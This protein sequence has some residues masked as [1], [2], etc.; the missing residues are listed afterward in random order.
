M[1]A[2]SCS[3]FVEV[4]A[5]KEP[6]PGGGGAS[7][8][9]GAIG[10]A[11]GN[12]TGSLTAGKKKYADVEDEVISLKQKADAL[13]GRLIELVTRDAEV[14]APLARA[15]RLPTGTESQRKHKAEIMEAC[16]RRCCAVP[17]EIMERCCEA[18][19]ICERLAA[20]GAAIAISDVGCG[21][22]C[23]RAALEAASLNVFIN[24]ASMANRTQAETINAQAR[25]MLK[26][27]V[28]KAN[29]IFADVASR[30]K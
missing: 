21:V 4:L 29:L 3:D 9:V 28:A 18:I 30:F 19:D 13:Q 24:T 23:L 7:A 10:T 8:L 14:F 20:V 25:Q 16:L 12:M 17:L 1:T 11:L 5:S 26:V 15:Y 6:V 22:A 2:R 27:Y